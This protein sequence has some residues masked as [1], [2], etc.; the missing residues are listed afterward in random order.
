MKIQLLIIVLAITS[1]TGCSLFA[2]PLPTD[3]RISEIAVERAIAGDET[4]SQQVANSPSLR[5]LSLNMAHGRKNSFT[6]KHAH[7]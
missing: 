5:V 6:K 7:L 3:Q 1:L 4:T 2:T